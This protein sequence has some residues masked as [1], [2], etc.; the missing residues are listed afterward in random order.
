MNRLKAAVSAVLIL[1]L[2]FTMSL[3]NVFA[4]GEDDATLSELTVRALNSGWTEIEK[5]SSFTFSPTITEYD[6]VLT[7]DTTY[8]QISATTSDENASTSLG[9]YNYYGV[10]EGENTKEIVVTSS[11][12]TTVTYTLTLTVLTET[13]EAEYIERH[14][15]DSS[16]LATTVIDD[17]TYYISPF[18]PDATEIPNGFDKDTY[19]MDGEEY[20]VVVNSKK[21][22]TA[23]WL[24][25]DSELTEGA[26]YVLDINGT[27]ENEFY[28][29]QNIKIK[30]RMYTIVPAESVET[31]VDDKEYFEEFTLMDIT[32]GDE[33]VEAWELVE[34]GDFYLLY[35]ANW[36]GDVSIY[37]YDANEECFQRYN[38]DSSTI[39]QLEAAGNSYTELQ[40]KYNNLVSKY[41]KSNS[42]KWK[43]IAALC[44]LCVIFIF[45]IINLILRLKSRD[46]NDG[47]SSGYYDDDD[48]DDEITIGGYEELSFD[49]T[50]E[51]ENAETHKDIDDLEIDAGIDLD[52]V[53]G[54]GFEED[55]TEESRTEPENEKTD[56]KPETAD[57]KPEEFEEPTDTAA[58][59]ELDDDFEFID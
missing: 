16:Q 19:T 40:S 10:S 3:T 48:D 49:R 11:D 12:G 53:S 13:E 50:A 37:C 32:I 29:L 24:Y 33:T 5:L 45:V 8:V 28:L 15:L 7:H 20:E 42:L 51:S 58:T 18:L 30:S 34:D 6:V 26:L 27:S 22:M 31:Y 1:A 55:Y 25:S 52:V 46:N 36:N 44:V 14:S 21:N 9:S 57:T 59:N 17:K 43:V 39:Q 38:I 56:I 35:A 41:N 4:E 2:M 54:V 47:D 23:F